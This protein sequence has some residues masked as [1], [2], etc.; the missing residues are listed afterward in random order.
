MVAGFGVAVG[1]G[2]RFVNSLKTAIS[3]ASNNVVMH[4]YG[5]ASGPL[6]ISIATVSEGIDVS[7]EDNGGGMARISSSTDRLG[8]GLAVISSLADR[9]EFAHRPGGGTEVRLL[10]HAPDVA[11][12]SGMSSTAEVAGVDSSAVLPGDVVASLSG[13]SLLRDVLGHVSRAV[14]A[15]SHFRV[16]RLSDLRA[17]TDAISVHADRPADQGPI[18][19][20]LAGSSRRLELNVGP[21]EQLDATSTSPGD[22]E[23]GWARL[24]E[25]VDQL[26]VERANGRAV[27]RVVVLD[28]RA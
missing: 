5:G 7:V 6:A 22:R 2:E 13:T 25:L 8:L 21:F 12:R 14:A 20:A 23:P 1:L 9:A 11:G 19:F 28:E 17:I 3:E 18:S 15:Q 24:A 26:T 27:L 16:S 4:A 10:F